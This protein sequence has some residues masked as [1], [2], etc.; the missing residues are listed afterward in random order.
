MKDEKFATNFLTN[1][2]ACAVACH[3]LSFVVLD[4]LYFAAVGRLFLGRSEFLI[5]DRFIVFP[6]IFSKK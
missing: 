1:F 5:D 4:R 3:L 6:K 2:L